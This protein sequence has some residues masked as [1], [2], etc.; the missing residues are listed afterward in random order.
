M[1]TER[2]LSPK[3]IPNLQGQ[4]Q[5]FDKILSIIV[6]LRKLGSLHLF[7]HNAVNDEYLE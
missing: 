3:D 1:R 6:E 4:K 5:T 7:V 2:R